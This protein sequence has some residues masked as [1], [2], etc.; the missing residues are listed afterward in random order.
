[1]NNPDIKILNSK[2]K[3]LKTLSDW[4]N[5]SHGRVAKLSGSKEAS[6]EP[7]Y[8]TLWW[9]TSVQVCFAWHLNHVIYLKLRKK[10]L[11]SQ[12]R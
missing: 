7:S 6:N 2:T 5:F 10:I 8:E 11:L 3:K 12:P 4:R 9:S 1:M